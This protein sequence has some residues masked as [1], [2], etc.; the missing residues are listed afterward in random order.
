MSEL[1]PETEEL[2]ERGRSGPT[3]SR[4]HRDELKG[5]VLAKLATG[6]VLTTSTGAAAWTLT[7]KVIGVAAVTAMVSVGT[8]GVVKYQAHA[9]ATQVASQSVAAP[10][11]TTQ[12]ASPNASASPLQMNAPMNAPMNATGAVETPQ[13]LPTAVPTASNAN[14]AITGAPIAGPSITG[15]STAGSS[16]S[17][18]H[19]NGLNS[20]PIVS[21]PG[22]MGSGNSSSGATNS[23]ATISGAS[24]SGGSTSNVAPPAAASHA[25]ASSLEEETTLLRA[26]VDAVAANDSARALRLLDEHAARFPSS[27]LEPER[28]AERVF[29]LCAGQRTD[30]AHVAAS[31]FLSV[32]STGPLASRVRASCGGDGG[33]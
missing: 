10:I 17:S 2:L 21:A 3:L 30:D 8:V 29:A 16:K 1:S 19:E 20:A 14:A 22:S 5:A 23:S 25:H 15:S 31:R 27:A 4:A 12:V 33:H 13:A 24:T 9:R 26:A 28:S 11:D 6:A 7:T 18:A 32:H